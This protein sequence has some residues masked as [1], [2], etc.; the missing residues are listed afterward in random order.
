MF[1]HNSIVKGNKILKLWT[2]M[3][4]LCTL[5]M[6]R[7]CRLKSRPWPN[8]LTSTRVVWKAYVVVLNQAQSQHYQIAYHW[9]FKM[10]EINL[11]LYRQHNEETQ[12]F[13][14]NKLTL[15]KWYD[16]VTTFKNYTNKKKSKQISKSLFGQYN[17]L[18]K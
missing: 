2:N 12:Y 11:T 10:H 15:V 4:F 5:P 6:M 9:S 18:Y 13:G 7:P 17:K 3:I 8:S 14:Q 1:W 16:T